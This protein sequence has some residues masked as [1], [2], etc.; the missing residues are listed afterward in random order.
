[1]I[2]TN[3]SLY[4]KG[5]HYLL[6]SLFQILHYEKFI[7]VLN[8]L[9]NFKLKQSNN[10]IDSLLFLY[11]YHHRINRYFMEGNFTAGILIVPQLVKQ[12]EANTHRLDR[13]RIMLFY[14]KIA[15]LYYGAG[16]T[17]KSI[18]YLNLIINREN[19]N[20]REDIQCFARLLNLMAHYDLGNGDLLPYQVKSLYRFLRKMK[21][22]QK[23]QSAILRFIRRLPK[24][25]PNDLK[26]E[27]IQLKN[28]LVIIRSEPYQL[29]PFLY[30][31]LISW[32]EGKI[33]GSSVQEVMQRD[34]RQ[35]LVS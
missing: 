7:A 33:E 17:E 32:L 29:R 30:L 24:I 14:F 5:I 25:R 15:S 19:P 31:D 34:F 21:D 26:Q 35:R 10:N 6:N 12:I 8:K 28:T 13:H 16:Q 9:E 1:M 11:R 18:D 2:A 4:L 22:I 20:F 3:P 27:F 23:V